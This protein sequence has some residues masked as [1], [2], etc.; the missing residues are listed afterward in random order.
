MRSEE[1]ELPPFK[2]VDRYDFAGIAIAVL[3]G[4]VLLILGAHVWAAIG[5]AGG[6]A[7]IA[8]FALRRRAGVPQVTLWRRAW[9]RRRRR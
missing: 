9:L 1:E 4:A 2:W 7:G 5:F 6:I 3:V 8:A